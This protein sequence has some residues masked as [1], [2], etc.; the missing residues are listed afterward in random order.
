MATTS[1]KRLTFFAPCPRGAEAL[2]AAELEECGAYD[3][4]PSG[5]GVAFTG[6]ATVGWRINVISRVASRILQRVAHSYYR[7]SED[8]YNLSRDT[9][10][11]QWHDEKAS[12]RVDITATRS[13]LQSLQ[14]ATLRVKD[15]ICDRYRELTGERPSVDTWQP[16]RRVMVFLTQDQCTLYLDWSGEPLFKRGWRE[17]ATDAPLKENLAATMLMLADW[18]QHD[19]FYDPFC[20][21][22]TLAIEAAL[23]VRGIVPGAN[24]R[25]GFETIKGF[26]STGWQRLRDFTVN[27]ARKQ[28]QQTTYPPIYANDITPGAL[29]IARENAHSA[30]LDSDAISFKQGDALLSK[31]PATSG[32]MVTNPPYGERLDMKGR[33]VITAEDQFWPLFGTMLKQQFSGWK[34]YLLTSDL[35]LPGQM[36]LKEVKRTP[37]FN[38]PIECRLFAFEMYQGSR[39]KPATE[40]LP[41]RPEN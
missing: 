14:F 18:P 5:G 4:V 8:V 27:D 2:L 13:P 30:G 26:D 39:R 1:P 41:A 29:A 3:I 11:E 9:G 21:S 34:A 32:V 36:R 20:G 33:Q 17:N 22:G 12:L 23:M 16:Q 31:A 7:N 19:A 24:R 25:F 6:A 28:S 10:W 38:G 37:L 40:A 15:G 35:K